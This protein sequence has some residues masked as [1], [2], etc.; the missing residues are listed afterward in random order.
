MQVEDN[1]GSVFV[2]PSLKK[3]QSPIFL[4]ES[5]I[6]LPHPKNR[7]KTWSLQNSFIMHDQRTLWWMDWD[8]TY[9]VVK[10]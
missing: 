8:M 2:V 10:A 4:A 5:D 1:D 9:V 7:T 6:I 3:N